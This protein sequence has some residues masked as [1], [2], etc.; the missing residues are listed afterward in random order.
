MS[1]CDRESDSTPSSKTESI[2]VVPANN[3]VLSKIPYID[4]P[5]KSTTEPEIKENMEPEKPASPLKTRFARLSAEYR[6][7]EIDVKTVTT[8]KESVIRGPVKRLSNSRP[9]VS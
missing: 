9:E 7:F 6:T 5:N 8:T 3:F 1:D 2:P 4:S